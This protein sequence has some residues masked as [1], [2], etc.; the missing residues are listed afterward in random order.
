MASSAPSVVLLGD[1]FLFRGHRLL[2]RPSLMARD[3]KAPGGGGPNGTCITAFHEAVANVVAAVGSDRN[4]TFP[5][6]VRRHC[7]Q[8]QALRPALAVLWPLRGR[9]RTWFAFDPVRPICAPACKGCKPPTTPRCLHGRV[10]LRFS[11][12]SRAWG[13]KRG[14]HASSILAEALGCCS[15]MTCLRRPDATACFRF[16]VKL[17]DSAILAAAT[18]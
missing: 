15:R 18:I 3:S 17:L 1:P 16:L 14:P 9:R 6:C 5:A 12:G 8:P 10:S 2:P 4:G 7:A 13:A 11:Y